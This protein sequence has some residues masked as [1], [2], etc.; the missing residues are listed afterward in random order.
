MADKRRSLSYARRFR[1][2][3]RIFSPAAEV[4]KVE[5]SAGSLL[6][7]RVLQRGY[8]SAHSAE[9]ATKGLL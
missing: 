6:S 7:E 5:P 2:G 4:D 9:Q 3:A 1:R 8:G